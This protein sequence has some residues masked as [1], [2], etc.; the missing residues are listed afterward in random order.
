MDVCGK[1]GAAAAGEDRDRVLDAV[2]RRAWL[3][4]WETAVRRAGERVTAAL[5][6]EVERAARRV[7]MSR[8][9][10]RRRLLPGP[11]KRAIAARVAAGG[12]PPVA[13]PHPLRAGATRVGEA[14]VL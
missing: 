14:R 3:G 5:G 8:R 4:A 10:L 7:R 12:E 6:G 1:A 2:S 11:E 13:A 9:L